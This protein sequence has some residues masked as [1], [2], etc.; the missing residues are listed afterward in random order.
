M[1]FI[2]SLFLFAIESRGVRKKSTL[3]EESYLVKIIKN[4][5]ELDKKVKEQT[6]QDKVFLDTTNATVKLT[7]VL[8]C[9]VTPFLLT[10][11]DFY[12][13]MKSGK[14]KLALVHQKDVSQV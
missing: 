5:G 7:V 1:T 8:N 11:K 13:R 4:K 14:Q 9:L 10:E 12:E 2:Y 3:D 6:K